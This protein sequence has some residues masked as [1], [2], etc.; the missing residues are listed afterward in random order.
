MI[1]WLST[2]FSEKAQ[3]AQLIA[4]II[5][6]IIAISVVCLNQYFLSKRAKKDIYMKKIE[7]FYNSI[8]QYE[9]AGYEHIL[10][11]CTPEELNNHSRMINDAVDKMEMIIHLYFSS[12]DFIEKYYREPFDQDKTSNYIEAISK[13][14]ERVQEL[15]SKSRILMKRYQH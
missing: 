9:Q 2:I 6:A 14:D 5:S 8:L 11:D 3:Q 13:L 7:E 15:K 1:A 12:L 10:G 4:I